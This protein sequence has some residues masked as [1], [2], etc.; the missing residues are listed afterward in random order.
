MTALPKPIY[1]A[2]QYLALEATAEYRSQ[3]YEGEIYAMAGAS[4][5]HNVAAGNIYADLH[6]QLRNRPCEIYQN[7][8]RVKVAADFYTYPDIVIVCGEPQIEKKHGENL[9]NPKVIIEVL[10]PSTEK[11]DRGEKARLYRLMPSLEEYVLIAQNARHL[12]HFVRQANGGWLLTELSDAAEFLELPTI[13][14]RVT[15]GDIYA[16]IDFSAEND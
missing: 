9:L 7:D 16:K 8:M 1:N 15:L 2:E 12:E 14:C 11:F 13:D 6:F 5:R 3:F 4:R 10:S